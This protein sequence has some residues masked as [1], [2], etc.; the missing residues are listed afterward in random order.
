MP[1]IQGNYLSGVKNLESLSV[2]LRNGLLRYLMRLAEVDPELAAST[3]RYVVDG[4]EEDVLLTLTTRPEIATALLYFHGRDSS[5]GQWERSRVGQN[6]RAVIFADGKAAPAPFWGRL[7]QVLDA[8]QRASGQTPPTPEGCP[9][10]FKVLLVASA[11]SSRG[12]DPEPRKPWDLADL[13]A[14]L[15]WLSGSMRTWSQS[16]RRTRARFSRPRLPLGWRTTSRRQRRRG[17]RSRTRKS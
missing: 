17:R 10:W 3:L 9:S 6:E 8:A 11:W 4:G 12:R 13:E 2:N 7:A 1:V 5:A 16:S 14:V 15:D